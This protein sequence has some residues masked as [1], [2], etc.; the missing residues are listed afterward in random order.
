M[1]FANRRPRRFLRF[2]LAFEAGSAHDP[3]GKEGLATLAASMI[4]DAGSTSRRIDEITRAIFPMAGSFHA[5]VDKELATFTG[6]IHRDNLEA[7]SNIAFEQLNS[8]G[9]RES[10]FERLK[11]EQRNALIQDLRT[12]NDEEFGK[13]RLQTNAFAGSGYGHPALGTVSGIDAI[14]LDDVRAFISANYTRANLRTG[15]A[16]DVPVAFETRLRIELGKLPA[17]E[18]PVRPTITPIQPNGLEIEIVEKE[19]RATAISFGHPLTVTRKD[20]VFAALWLARSWL[21]EHRASNG[22]LF[23]QLASCAA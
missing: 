16:G 22:R 10:D 14:T 7:F 23:Q 8:P 20:P 15:L 2:K 13:E 19:T 9:F 5:Q 1:S 11:D 3:K 4:T 17:G 21:G 18:P 12:N 6:V